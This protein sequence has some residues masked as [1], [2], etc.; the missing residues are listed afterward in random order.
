[1]TMRALTAAVLLVVAYASAGAAQEPPRDRIRIER[2]ADLPRHSYPVDTTA[3]ALLDDDARFGA[4]ARQLEA[5][6]LSDLER[7]IIEDRATLKGYYDGLADLALQ[8]GNHDRAVAF[9]DSIRTIEE[10]PGLRL[11]AGIVE[12]AVAEAS[13]APDDRFDEAFHA[14]FRRIVAALPYAEV[15]AEL[16]T[17]RGGLEMATPNA[18]LGWVQAM[19]EPSARDGALS[20]AEAQLL[21]KV[22]AGKDQLVPIR[23][24]AIEV[25][26]ET[27]AANAAETPD[28]W[29]ERDVSLEGRTDLT[30][31]VVAIWDSGF[32]VDLFPGRLF[33]NDG[34][35]PANGEDD[36]GNG[37]VDDVHG[38]A[39]NLD[40]VRTTGVLG[41]VTASPAELADYRRYLSGQLDVMAGLESSE[42]QA[43]KQKVSSMPPAEFR[44][45]LDG[46]N[47]YADYAH[48]THVAGIA[49]RDNPAARGLVA[50][51]E[52]DNWKPMPQLVTTE[53]ERRRAREYRET[54][55]YFKR[56]GVRVVNMS[57]AISP[58]YYEAILGRNQAG[59]DDDGRR[60]L[61]REMYEIAADALRSAMESAPEIL[62]FAAGLNQDAD[63][64][65]REQ[66]PAA[67]DLPNLLTV[68]AVDRAGKEA[69]FTSYGKID[70]YANGVHVPSFVPGGEVIPLNG[71]SMA[72]PQVVNLAA[73]LLALR[74]DLTVA[75]LRGAILE[76]ADDHTVS[77]GRTIRLM[78]P[79]AAVERVAVRQEVEVRR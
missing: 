68:G 21:V 41:P 47:F 50:R 46:M 29:A 39:Y 40:H 54:I 25:L 5:D 67:F 63:N 30:T 64:R 45:W 17:I 73:K 27:I 66:I 23:D 32:D 3:A 36:D 22:R 4:L 58:N 2:A 75:Q 72:T 35:I 51:N 61:A 9:K 53:G 49:L 37:H 31:V 70:V 15:Q 69:A 74:P 33:V 1:M 79:R 78:N 6:L 16:A 14:S 12:R 43:F 10:K 77:E 65:F 62:F 20:R 18:M 34:E 13:R 7:Y 56:Y 48:G 19:L 59:G 11:T 8:R 42:A 57:W 44:P 28:I 60:R 71:T 38:I 26:G 24:A 55:D 76:A 52:E